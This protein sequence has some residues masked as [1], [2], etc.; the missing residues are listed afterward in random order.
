MEVDHS[1]LVGVQTCAFSIY[2]EGIEHYLDVLQKAAKAN[3]VFIFHVIYPHFL[4]AAKQERT[5]HYKE[6]DAYPKGIQPP[7]DPGYYHGG[8]L[9]KLHP[10]RPG[11]VRKAFVPF[12]QEA[13]RLEVG[14]PVLL[15]WIAGDDRYVR[16]CLPETLDDKRIYVVPTEVVSLDEA[17][18]TAKEVESRKQ[19]LL[20]RE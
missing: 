5:P 1:V 20:R 14:D 16:L 2:E 13:V 15:V 19:P 7:H 9:L 6:I 8:I 12:H 17:T 18:R 4:N 10:P 3:A 11:F